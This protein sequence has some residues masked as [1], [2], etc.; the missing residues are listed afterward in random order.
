[1][2]GR[3]QAFK[4]LIT[5]RVKSTGANTI[6]VPFTTLLDTITSVVE[7]S[8]DFDVSSGDN[9]LDIRTS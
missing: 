2:L 5:S 6:N 1:M 9:A 3:L 7:F 4:P 8:R